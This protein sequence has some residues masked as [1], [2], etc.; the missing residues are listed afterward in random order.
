MSCESFFSQQGQ[1]T[2]PVFAIAEGEKST[3][4]GSTGLLFT[5]N[6]LLLVQA[7]KAPA[8]VF[9]RGHALWS[10]CIHHGSSLIDCD[11]VQ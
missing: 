5:S 2:W 10:L 8:P 6:V 3:T 1:M 7:L 11:R 4:S 9:R